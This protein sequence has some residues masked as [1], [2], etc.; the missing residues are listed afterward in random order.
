[1]NGAREFDV[2]IIG[3]GHNGLTCA[4]YLAKAG[5]N[6]L[7]LERAKLVGGAASTAEST[8]GFKI[9]FGA[10]HHIYVPYSRVVKELN[11]YQQGLNY[12]FP[13]PLAASHFE[14]QEEHPCLQGRREDGW[15]HRKILAEGRQDVSQHRIDL[16]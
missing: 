14:D 2:I 8:P 12:V 13:D 3:A 16:A 15:I 5:L 6:V 4:A 7:V 1:M 10:L 11:L 9:E